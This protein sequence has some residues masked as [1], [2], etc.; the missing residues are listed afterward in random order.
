MGLDSTDPAWPEAYRPVYNLALGEGTP[1]MAYRY[2]QHVLAGQPVAQVVVGLE[3]EYFLDQFHRDD[4]GFEAF[5]AVG[6]DGR[7]VGRELQ[8]VRDSTRSVFLLD[9][10]T[11]SIGTFSANI[12]PMS[13]DIRRGTGT[14]RRWTTFWCPGA[15]MDSSLTTSSPLLPSTGSKG[16]ARQPCVDSRHCWIYARL[17]ELA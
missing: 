16:G 14:G 15:R 10:L 6:R 4:L 1:Y 8:R 7:P 2:T 3:F 11:N 9:A 12:Q 5:L 17:T 13:S